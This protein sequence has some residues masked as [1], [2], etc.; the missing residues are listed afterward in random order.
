MNWRA[1]AIL[2]LLAPIGP[3]QAD[4]AG[5]S[6]LPPLREV[7][8]RVLEESEKEKSLE[9]AFNQNY[10]Y[11]RVKVMEHRNGKGELKKRSERISE[12]Q[13]EPP[14]A[15]GGNE[16]HAAT[17]KK[18]AAS[19]DAEAKGRAYE[20]RDF[21]ISEDLLDRF[22]FSLIGREI[23]NGRP[24][25]VI[26]FHPASQKL[27]ERSLK[28]R[29]LNRTAGKVWVDEAEFL[30]AKARFYLTEKVNVIGGLVGAVHDFVCDF[31]RERTEDGLWF[32]RAMN[33]HLEGRELFSRRTI[34]YREERL[35]VRKA[36]R[37]AATTTAGGVDAAQ[38]AD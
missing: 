35:N 10:Q 11:T 26:R 15:E 2:T 34:D 5:E 17:E 14:G 3:L 19:A 18:R 20:E 27:P 25:L 38:A 37:S 28:E 7:L 33:W 13:P 16:A 1:A 4:P 22:E 23:I 24:A 32:T 12:R 36:G 31:E 6:T 30:L 21:S 9:R 29:F 8:R